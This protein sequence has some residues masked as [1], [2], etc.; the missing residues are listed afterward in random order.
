MASA[1]NLA[2]YESTW[3]AAAALNAQRGEKKKQERE[4][5]EEMAEIPAV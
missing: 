1:A 5:G 4:I 3:K 2:F